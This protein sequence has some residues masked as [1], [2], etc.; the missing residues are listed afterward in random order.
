MTQVLWGKW[1]MTR[2]SLKKRGKDN[3]SSTPHIPATRQSWWNLPT[4]STTSETSTAA[5]LKVNS[6]VLILFG[7]LLYLS[8]PAYGHV[9]STCTLN[10]MISAKLN[11]VLKYFMFDFS[12]QPLLKIPI[13][14][15]NLWKKS[16]DF[17]KKPS[18]T[19]N[20]TWYYVDFFLNVYQV[21]SGS[22]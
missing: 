6:T 14:C 4:N 2:R 1:R 18:I 21:S 22:K 20:D 13:Q 16:H 3:R 15:C 9:V 19:Q 17:T 10:C 7:E 11:R 8:D 5:H 12:T